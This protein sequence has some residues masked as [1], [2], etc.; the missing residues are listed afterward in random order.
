MH[1]QIHWKDMLKCINDNRFVNIDDFDYEI[2]KKFPISPAIDK[3]KWLSII[4]DK[5]KEVSAQC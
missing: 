3:P 1:H 2:L 5:N 4:I